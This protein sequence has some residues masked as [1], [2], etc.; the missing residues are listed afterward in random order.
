MSGSHE[1]FGEVVRGDETW[2]QLHGGQNILFFTGGCAVEQS[3]PKC[4]W[5]TI[6]MCSSG[7]GW[8]RSSKGCNMRVN[9]KK[10]MQSLF[11]KQ[12]CQISLASNSFSRI[13]EW[14]VFQPESGSGRRDPVLAL[15]ALGWQV[16]GCSST[17][18]RIHWDLRAENR[19]K[20]KRNV[21]VR[22]ACPESDLHL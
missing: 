16:K 4:V 13:R 2:S 11:M 17:M 1:V 19:K 22:L 12:Q 7:T 20:K 8:E 14:R 5:T 10:K 3:P 21:C 9:K 6:L 18:S 15:A